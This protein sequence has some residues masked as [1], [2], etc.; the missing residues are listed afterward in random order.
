MRTF[1][2]RTGRTWDVAVDRESWGT[3]VLIF[4]ERRGPEVRRAVLASQSIHDAH[5]ELAALDD[6]QLGAR[7]AEA[8]PCR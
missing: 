8:E 7:L 2:D 6:E 4:A 3:F 1:T 5:A